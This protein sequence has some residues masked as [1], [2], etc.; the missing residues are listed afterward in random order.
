MGSKRE[1][2]RT[3]DGPKIHRGVGN[4]SG[5]AGFRRRGLFSIRRITTA[6]ANCVP[7]TLSTL[8]IDRHS[9][10]RPAE[11]RGE[12]S[13]LASHA[14]PMLPLRPPLLSVPVVRSPRRYHLNRLGSVRPMAR[15]AIAARRNASSSTGA[16]LSRI[17]ATITPSE[18]EFGGVS[19]SFPSSAA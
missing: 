14:L 2:L 12:I 18:G 4:C 6:K 7:D 11:F 1:T 9:Q 16:P 13:L 5:A 17:I 8:Q 15:Y 10:R 19:I 3:L